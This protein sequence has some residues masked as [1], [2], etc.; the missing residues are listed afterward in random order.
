MLDRSRDLDDGWD[1]RD[2]PRGDGLQWN[3]PKL[4]SGDDDP[5]PFHPGHWGLGSRNR[6]QDRKGTPLTPVTDSQTRSH[7]GRD[8]P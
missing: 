2:R 5:C 4:E 6:G 8:S 3:L 7:G 1:R